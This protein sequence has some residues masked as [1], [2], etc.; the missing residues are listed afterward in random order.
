LIQNLKIGFTVFATADHFPLLDNLIESVLA[1]SRYPIKVVAINAH[2]KHSSHRVECQSVSFQRLNYCKIM[3]A[4]IIGAVENDFDLGLVLD[5]DMLVV[6]EIDKIFEFG[7]SA[8]ISQFPLFSRHPHNPIVNPN[9]HAVMSQLMRLITPNVPSMGWVYASFLFGKTNKWFLKETIDV[10]EQHID[11]QWM[12]DELVLNALLS[13]YRVTNDAGCNWVVNGL[14]QLFEDYFT[15]SVSDEQRTTYLINHCP[16]K[17]FLFHGHDC[18]DP[19]KMRIW[20]D[21]LKLRFGAN[22]KTYNI[23]SNRTINL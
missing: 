3:K 15:N 12:Q 6:P 5:S 18:K 23:R 4:K 16:L 2:Y 10:L 17:M 8:T 9:H 22:H 1:F 7:V 13:K 20:L 21:R 11:V 14:P 19:A